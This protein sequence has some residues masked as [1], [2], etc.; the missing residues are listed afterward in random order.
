M[1]LS[2]P[3]IV[4]AVLPHGEHGAVVRALTPA[5]GLLAGYVRGGRGRRLRPVLGL[6]NAVMAGF[7]ARLETQ[8]PALTVELTQ[9]RAALAFDP[10]AAAALDWLCALA[11]TALPEAQ[12]MPRTHAR[13]DALLTDMATAPPLAWMADLARFELSLLAD[14]G[15]GLDLT[16]CAVTG[17]QHDLAYVSP[18]SRTAVSRAAGTPY[19][20]RLLPLAPLL[21][22]APAADW[23]EVADA[24]RTTGHFLAR[25]LLE[26]RATRIL[27]AR[28]R[29]E[30][31]VARP[32]R[33]MS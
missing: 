18:K 25:D 31:L 2:T 10:L 4:V 1:D 33:A 19:A 3:A 13:L 21:T 17:Q 30:A 14:L 8:L 22:G 12:P 11:A 27:P 16:T 15:F 9:S 28:E 6:G 24:L 5:H 20:A 26:A 23:P 32:N 29:L 7:R